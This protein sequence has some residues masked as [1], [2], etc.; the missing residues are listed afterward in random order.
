MFT[1]Q[2]APAAEEPAPVAEEAAPEPAQEEVPVEAPTPEVSQKAEPA[3][4]NTTRNYI[5]LWLVEY[6]WDILEHCLYHNT[7]LVKK[8]RN[9]YHKTPSL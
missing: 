6:L 4:V 8:C 2:P 7:L 9:I 1:E 5:S 3:E